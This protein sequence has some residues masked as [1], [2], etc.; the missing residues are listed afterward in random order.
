MNEIQLLFDMLDTFPY[1]DTMKMVTGEIL[2]QAFFPGGKGIF[3]DGNIISDKEIMILG[4]D[5]DCETNYKKS[6]DQ[7]KEDIV[8]NPTW[9]NLLA[10]LKEL[11]ISP[12]RCFFTNAIL[13]VRAGDKGT[14]KSP[15]FKHSDFI[16]HCQKFFLYQIEMQRPKAIF[17]LGKFTAKFF[18][19]LSIKLNCWTQIKN[20]ETLDKNGHPVV[21]DVEFENGIKSNLVLL[22]HPPFRPANIKRRKYDGECGNN[23]EMKMIKAALEIVDQ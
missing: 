22:T 7:G 19:E 1:P 6:K 18:A 4:Q 17:V 15:A 12:D 9:R 21:M 2:G 3:N 13:G 16:K 20:F 11:N 10:V 14:G 23:A 5:F 8:K